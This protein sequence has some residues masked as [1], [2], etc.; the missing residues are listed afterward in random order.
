MKNTRQNCEQSFY[1]KIGTINAS[2]SNLGMLQLEVYG[3]LLLYFPENTIPVLMCQLTRLNFLF[4]HLKFPVTGNTE[5]VICSRIR[6]LHHLKRCRL[7]VMQE[8]KV[9]RKLLVH[10]YIALKHVTESPQCSYLLSEDVAVV[11]SY[12]RCSYV[13]H[14]NLFIYW[15]SVAI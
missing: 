9:K 14:S 7:V 13:I 5:A 15:L 11:A 12:M 10:Q 3:G 4:P 6:N 8:G 1:H 2:K